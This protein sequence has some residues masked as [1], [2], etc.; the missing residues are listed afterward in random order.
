[1]CVFVG[2]WVG[3][4]V[5]VCGCGCGC[6]WVRVL[7]AVLFVGCI[8][9]IETNMVCV[10]TFKHKGLGAAVCSMIAE[11]RVIDRGRSTLTIPSPPSLFLY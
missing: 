11:S 6:M 8:L 10:D 9:D 4:S 2:L 7:F 3:G 1:V 5:G